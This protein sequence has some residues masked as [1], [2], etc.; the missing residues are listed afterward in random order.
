MKKVE[1]MLTHLWLGT[2][3]K[4][5]T[6][7]LNNMHLTH[8]SNL[9]RIV[10]IRFNRNLKYLIPTSNTKKYAI[11]QLVLLQLLKVYHS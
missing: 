10:L 4:N 6:V 1:D 3:L 7:Q 5:A 2:G 8:K 11:R 9:K